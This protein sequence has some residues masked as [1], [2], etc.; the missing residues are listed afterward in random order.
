MAIQLIIPDSIA[1][2][3]KLPRG[4]RGRE[5]QVELAVALY[6]RGI[7]GFG[8]ARDL[9]GMS[10]YGFGLALGERGIARHYGE[11]DLD[12]DLRYARGQ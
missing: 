11:T 6:A 4:D 1:E 5:L 9:A 10:K 2:A 12:D 7:L 8:K 3:L